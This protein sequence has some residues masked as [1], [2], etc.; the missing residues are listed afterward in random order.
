MSVMAA[1]TH[2][3]RLVGTVLGLLGLD[4]GN[5]RA[6]ANA[7]G[8]L[9]GLQAARKEVDAL[10]L[11]LAQASARLGRGLAR[12]PPRVSAHAHTANGRRHAEARG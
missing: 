1:P 12:I 11:R 8:I 2:P 7:R 10:E 9:E 5:T 6:L 4:G 3:R